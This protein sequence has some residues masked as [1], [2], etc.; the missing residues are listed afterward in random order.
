MHTLQTEI[1]RIQGH[2]VYGR[3]SGIQ[4]LLVEVAGVARS[5]SIGSRVNILSRAEK[6]IPCEVVGFK[7]DH[8]LLM[9]YSVLEGVGVGCKAFVDSDIANVHPCEAWL[10][11]VVNAMGEPIDGK[12]P[13]KFGHEAYPVRNTPPPAHLR[14]RVRGKMDLGV[15]SINTFLTCCKGQRC[16]PSDQ[17]GLIKGI[18]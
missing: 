13:I 11:R 16:I 2:K 5:L 18:A 12:G 15:R 3:V 6:I 9:P 17:V 7:S 4:G 10:G 8:A 14:G 1:E